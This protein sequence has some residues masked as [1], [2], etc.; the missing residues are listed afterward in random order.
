MEYNNV[1]LTN[2]GIR[3]SPNFKLETILFGYDEG[4]N[5]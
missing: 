1:I 5:K 4:F 3:I 2:G